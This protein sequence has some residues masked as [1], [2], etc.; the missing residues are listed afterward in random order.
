MSQDKITISTHD[1]WVNLENYFIA[2]PKYLLREI[3]KSQ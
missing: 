2:L 1:I 3:K